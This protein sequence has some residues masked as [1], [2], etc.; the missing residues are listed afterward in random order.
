MEDKDDGETDF[1]LSACNK[2][3]M[4]GKGCIKLG[5]KKASGDRSDY[6]IKTARIVR[7]FLVTCRDLLSLKPPGKPIF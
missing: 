3:Q 4:I 7:R 5:N 1:K 2:L 6:S